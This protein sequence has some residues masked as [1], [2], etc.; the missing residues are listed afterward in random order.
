MKRPF[1]LI[2]PLLAVFLIAACGGGDDNGGGANA[3]GRT[4]QVSVA[5]AERIATAALLTVGDLPN[6]VTWT[7]SED[8][9]DAGDTADEAGADDSF[10]TAPACEGF[11][12][13]S[14]AEEQGLGGVQE[15]QR[16]SVE[17]ENEEGFTGVNLD[18][19]IIIYGS[20]RDARTAF[21]RGREILNDTKGLQDCFQAALADPFTAEE[22]VDLKKIEVSKGDGAVN[23]DVSVVVVIEVDAGGLEIR[24]DLEMHAF[25]RGPAI[26]LVNTSAINN[27][28]LS[29]ELDGLVKLVEGRLSE[30][31]KG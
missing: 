29:S 3:S 11:R 17:F 13:L 26:S 31:L 10:Q 24:F 21:A 1:W 22:G 6:E 25:Q 27:N 8:T 18:H 23:G 7:V 2:V 14:D 19:D 4:A 30:A 16:R 15:I 20:E 28:T 5:D 9:G 12:E